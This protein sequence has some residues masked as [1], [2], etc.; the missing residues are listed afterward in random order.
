MSHL[1]IQDRHKSFDDVHALQ[2]V[3]I[4]VEQGEFFV[5]LGP[6]AAGKTTTLRMICGIE[7]ADRGRFLFDG[8]DITSAGVPSA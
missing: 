1:I 3:D 8:Q 2:G 6:S 7:R 5:L 4:T